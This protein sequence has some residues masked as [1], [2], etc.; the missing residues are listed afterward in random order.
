M[1]T[2][3]QLKE[4]PVTDA[5]LLLFECRLEDGSLERWSTHRVQFAGQT[6]AARVLR[7]NVFE[8]QT[9]SDQGV[10]A[11]PKISL[12]LANADSHFSEIERSTGF[13]GARITVH[14]L[15]YDLRAGSPTTEDMVLFQGVAN[16]P[17]EITE[18]SFRVSATNRMSLQRLLLP[19]VRIQRRCPWEFPATAEQ[20]QEAADG[21]ERGKWSIYYRCGYSADIEPGGVGNLDSGSPFVSC[22]F[23]RVDCEARGMFRQDNR[24]RPTGRFGGV[25]FVPSS[26]VVRSYGEKGSHTVTSSENEARYNDF[27]PLLYGTTWTSPLIAF[28]RNDGNLTHIEAILGMGEIQ[29]ILKLLVNDIEIPMGRSGTNMTGTGWYNVITLGSRNGS[30][31]LDFADKDGK[32][33]GD[34]Y[35]S[36]AALSV[37]VPNRISDGRSLPS[38]KALVQGQ[39]LLT[40]RIDG[41]AED[42]VFS[43]NPVWVLLDVLLRSGWRREEIEPLSFAA[44]AA[45]CDELIETRDIYGSPMQIP[46]FRCNLAVKTRRSAGDL[47][48][49]VRNS[50][51]LF[52]TYGK[53]GLLELRVE[54]TIAL[55]QPSK[56]EWSS[57]TEKLDGG[58]PYYEF[59]DGAPT[60]SGRLL[61]GIRRRDSGE[62]SLRV[63]SRS[64]ADTPNRFAVE[65]QDELNEYQQDSLSLIDVV[66]A[67]KTG[68][69]IT[70]TLPALGLPNF[71]QA[72]RLIKFNLDKSI[73]GNCYVEFETSV[74]SVGLQPGDI[75]ALTYLKEGFNRQPFR[76]LKI[77]PG[78]NYRMALITA[79]IHKDEWYTDTNGQLSFD[80][81]GR[82]QPDARARVP[83][84]LVGSK[85][86]EFGE[87][88]FEVVE[89]RSEGADGGV[90]VELSV[91][92]IAPGSPKTSA[93]GIPLVSLEAG[94]ETTGG[95]LPPNT[96]FYYAI[97]SAGAEDEE[98][99]LSFIVRATTPDGPS[100]NRIKLKGI[101]LPAEATGFHVYRGPS[102]AELCR[103]ATNQAPAAEFNDSGL[104][105]DL[106]APPDA[107]YDHANF[108]WRLELQPEYPAVVHSPDTIGNAD[109]AMPVNEYADKVVRITRGTGAGQERRILGNNSTILTVETKWDLEPDASSFFVVSEPSWQFGARCRT[110][111]VQFGIPNRAGA[112]IQISGRSANVSDIECS[113]ELSPLTRWQIGGGSDDTGIPG[114]PDFGLHAPGSGTLE[115]SGVGFEDLSN[116][117]TISS[118]TLT[119]FY[120]NELSSPCQIYLRQAIGADDQTIELDPAGPAGPGDIV[121]VDA[122][123]MR[124]EE[125]LDGGRQYSVL[126]A[127]QG[128]KAAE[129]PT[130][131]A[132]YHLEKHV[133]I[134]PFARGFFGSPYSGSW[135]YSFTLPDVRVASA[136]L[137]VTNAQGESDSTTLAFSD[138]LDGGLRTLSGGQYT[139]QVE[140]VL[141]IQSDATPAL[142]IEAS[143]AVRDVYAV[144]R[145]PSLDGEIRLKL[146]QD[147]VKYCELVID[148]GS[149]ISHAVDGF[150]M[151]PLVQGAKLSVDVTATGQASP[152]SDLTII[153]RL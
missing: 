64:T 95:T 126:R 105:Q 58:W 10:D 152:G 112:W 96:T 57:A 107:A 18:S 11:I 132:V 71:D 27:V 63:W 49:G 1:Q 111:P 70:A 20:R 94:V 37:V 98:S 127:A 43:N 62:S 85:L 22:G 60:P 106:V 139:L 77:A 143:H 88:E 31:S 116:T 86:N 129:H 92:F 90:S 54:D 48:R 8:I 118:G 79:Q 73:S 61:S 5:P 46:R 110:S 108:Y 100:T 72:A 2:I 130:R 36:I 19:G 38:M 135:S 141:A 41:A 93:P 82:R 149:L 69:E 115:L 13:K 52:L 113:Y 7:H 117:R 114:A 145:E 75:I 140:G 84:P 30:A 12:T 133:A 68:Q 148:K 137:F 67:G 101:S 35:G 51:R 29:G 6:Y 153:I 151:P 9:A 15:F 147:G 14:F 24:Q 47:I 102:P 131:S 134:T 138:G 76:I 78:A 120:W 81:E 55:Q 40:F 87:A 25:E 146:T 142:V 17:E 136:Q 150:G 123:I 59:G 44:A 119:V 42:G 97:S 34:P 16:P 74:R 104:A 28:A 124:I 83:R 144:V 23:T 50:S 125:S 91:G 66:D 45:Y 4:Q 122:E 32:P 56:P 121:Q 109:L 39:K 26:I 65:F 80:S 3:Y 128:S 21:G 89:T 103:I 53:G 99:P 33:L